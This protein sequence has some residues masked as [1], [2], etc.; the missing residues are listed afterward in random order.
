MAA[1]LVWPRRPTRRIGNRF[2]VHPMEGW[3]GTEDGALP[4]DTLRQWRRFGRAACESSS[5]VARRTRSSPTDAPTRTAAPQPR[6]RRRQPRSV[7]VAAGTLKAGHAHHETTD[8]LS[9]ACNSPTRA[10]SAT[11]GTRMSPRIAELNPVL[12]A[13]ASTPRWHPDRRQAAGD[14]DNMVKAACLAAD[15]GF[16][17][18]DVKCCHG[19]LLHELLGPT[20]SGDYGGPFENRTRLFRDTVT[21][22]R[23][24]HPTS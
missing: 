9:S 17:F 10:G 12:A 24:E 20:R 4:G 8:D 2:A 23:T 6:P 1:P 3:D 15:A 5:G 7:V 21:A 16:D 13:T 14:L 18:V 11:H 19:Y 22:I